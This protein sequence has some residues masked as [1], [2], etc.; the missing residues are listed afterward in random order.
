MS[1]EPE[2]LDLGHVAEIRDMPGM[3]GGSLLHEFVALF[4]REEPG[5]LAE[6]RR[7]TSAGQPREE[8]KRLAHSLAGS[9]AM[10]GALQM[11]QAALELQSVALA[12]SIPELAARMTAVDAASRRL[13]EAL[14]RHDLLP[15]A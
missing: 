6:L 2:V 1:A 7:L 13:Q 3:K 5:R 9:C 12:G 11:Q 15:N 4:Q 8:I 14:A 10:L